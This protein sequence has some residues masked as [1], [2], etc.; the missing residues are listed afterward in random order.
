MAKRVPIGLQISIN[1]PRRCEC[2]IVSRNRRPRLRRRLS[3]SLRRGS[4]I[5]ACGQG[6]RAVNGTKFLLHLKVNAWWAGYPVHTIDPSETAGLFTRLFGQLINKGVRSNNIGMS[7]HSMKLE[8][9]VQFQLAQVFEKILCQLGQS[10]RRLRPGL[11]YFQ[12][13]RRTCLEKW[14][15][16]VQRS[17]KGVQKIS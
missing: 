11:G 15:M 14:N 10:P 7:W 16:L 5:G 6:L 4:L 13:V 17:S 3:G 2:C 12:K 8:V 1:E 9:E